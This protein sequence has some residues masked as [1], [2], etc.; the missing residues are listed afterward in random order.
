MRFQ[1]IEKAVRRVGQLD[2]ELLIEGVEVCLSIE[3]HNGDFVTFLDA[4]RE[5]YF[6]CLLNS[7]FANASFLAVP[8]ILRQ[9]PQS[10]LHKFIAGSC[11]SKNFTFA[12]SN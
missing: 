12:L 3:P 4:A 6:I 5:L 2:N 9:L 7:S 1:I 11:H 10:R 8:L